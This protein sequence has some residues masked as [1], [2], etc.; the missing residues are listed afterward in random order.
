MF[1]IS[2]RS[3]EQVSSGLG[4]SKW[5]WL[6]LGLILL[7]GG[8]FLMYNN[9]PVQ[10][11]TILAIAGF[12]YLLVAFCA[13]VW[14][15]FNSLVDLRQRVRQGWAQVDVQLKR[16]FDLIP[17]IERVV[18]GLRDYEKNTQTELA[19]LRAESQATP[20][21]QPGP[22]Y[23]V[24]TGTGNIIKP[25]ITRQKPFTWCIQCGKRIFK[26]IKQI[27]I[28]G[29]PRLHLAS[30]SNKPILRDR[31]GFQVFPRRVPFMKSND[32]NVLKFFSR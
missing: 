25:A 16:R 14:M 11:Y 30:K 24:L 15:V 2:T 17:N 1:L 23:H 13:W 32:L 31:N 8:I 22:D 4:W 28:Q 12:I 26:V 10:N 19:R 7:L 18:K 21:G 27:L 3:E 6:F 20:P 5:G 29:I 9:A